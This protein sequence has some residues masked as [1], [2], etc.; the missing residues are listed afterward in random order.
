MFMPTFVFTSYSI[1]MSITLYY[2]YVITLITYDIFFIIFRHLLPN[3]I[4]IK[5]DYMN[6]LASEIA[7]RLKITDSDKE[8]IPYPIAVKSPP[9]RIEVRN[10]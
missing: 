6:M 8:M 1:M 4:S 2:I 5:Q 3:L 7:N 9:K 10:Y